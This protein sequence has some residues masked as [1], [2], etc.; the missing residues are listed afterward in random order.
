MQGKAGRIALKNFSSAVINWQRWSNAKAILLRQHP[1]DC[2]ARIHNQSR[3]SIP[4]GLVAVI[5][6]LGD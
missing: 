5:A 4:R 1:L 6:I 3:S 2:H